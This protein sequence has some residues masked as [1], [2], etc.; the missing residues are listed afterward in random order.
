[1]DIIT[2]F[3]SRIVSFT[4]HDLLPFTSFTAIILLFSFPTA[5]NTVTSKQSLS[6]NQTN[7]TLNS[8]FLMTL[9]YFFLI[10]MFCSKLTL[11][12][13]NY[14]CFIRLFPQPTSQRWFFV[15]LILLIV[16][17]ISVALVLLL[18]LRS[19]FQIVKPYACKYCWFY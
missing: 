19:T 9:V 11:A 17:I 7:C 5:L 13:L 6:I 1:M 15:M 10:F 14:L 3:R 18:H 12:Y 8:I 4:V 2:R 16:S